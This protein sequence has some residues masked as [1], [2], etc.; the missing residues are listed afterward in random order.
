MPR[1]IE[2]I[3]Y[4]GPLESSG[5]FT[6]WLREWEQT[7]SRNYYFWCLRGEGPP[8]LVDCG[9]GPDM[10]RD[11]AVNGYAN[12][13]EMVER[14]GLKAEK[15]QHL[16][17]THLHWDHANGVSLFPNARFYVQETE[18]RFWL[19][20]PASKRPPFQYL[21]DPSAT[22]HLAS[23]EGTDRLCLLDGDAEVLPGIRCLLAPGHTVGLQ[24]VAVDTAEGVAVLAADCAHTFR[25]LRE[26]WPSALIVDLVGWMHSFDKLRAAVSRPDLLFP[27]HDA[28]LA[29]DYPEVAPGITRLV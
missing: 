10:A 24:A 28:R 18:Y 2:A 7:V 21:A 16:V 4:A 29:S 22:A 27:G 13:A 15:V 11:R 1:T 3:C 8:V 5:A 25:N 19:E 17:L 12:P 14:I 9:V 6:M 23:L 20:D 26:D